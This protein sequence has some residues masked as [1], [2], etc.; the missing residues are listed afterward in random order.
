[1]YVY[2]QIFKKIN[3]MYLTPKTKRFVYKKLQAIVIKIYLFVLYIYKWQRAS[4]N[5]CSNCINKSSCTFGRKP[6]WQVDYLFSWPQRRKIFSFIEVG[7]SLYVSGWSIHCLWE[8]LYLFMVL[9]TKREIKRVSFSLFLIN[10]FSNKF[11]ANSNYSKLN[12]FSF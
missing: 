6:S 9:F 11:D 1:M 4:K 7:H 10:I 2:L 8:S 12:F 5:T 3:H